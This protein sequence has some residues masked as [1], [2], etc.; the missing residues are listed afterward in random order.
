M[1]SSTS[2]ADV[3]YTATSGPT[4]RD[5]SRDWLGEWTCPGPAGY[6]VRFLD[7]GNIAAVAIGPRRRVNSGIENASQF[8]GAGR[9]F[10]D[11]MQWLVVDGKPRA[12]VLRTWRLDDAER[13]QQQLDVYAID[14]D[15]ACVVESINVRTPAANER[16]LARATAAAQSGCSGR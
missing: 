13:E 5:A 11:K 16:A 15:S 9:V 2:H 6:V 7:E 8:R 14:G 1:S 4:C 10:G 12:A 3:V